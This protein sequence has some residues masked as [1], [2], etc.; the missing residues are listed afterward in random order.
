[1]VVWGAAWHAGNTISAQFTIDA[2]ADPIQPIRL[3]LR[4]LGMINDYSNTHGASCPAGTDATPWQVD[5]DQIDALSA[6]TFETL[7]RYEEAKATGD[8]C[9]FDQALGELLVG[10]ES[11]DSESFRY[12]KFMIMELVSILKPRIEGC[13]KPLSDDQKRAAFQRTFCELRGA[14]VEQFTSPSEW[15]SSYAQT[16]VTAA[17]HLSPTASMAMSATICAYGLAPGLAEGVRDGVNC[18]SGIR[19]PIPKASDTVSI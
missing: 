18:L 6:H 5:L 11:S 14:L 3:A 2:G 15:A 12:G 1:M 9:E 7:E 17:C 10:D 16:M 13:T 8:I 19:A 4:V